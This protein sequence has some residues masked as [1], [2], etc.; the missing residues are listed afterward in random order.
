MQQ[1]ATC[2][3][4]SPPPPFSFCPKDLLSMDATALANSALGPSRSLPRSRT[5]AISAHLRRGRGWS[6]KAVM[7]SSSPSGATPPTP[8][9]HKKKKKKKKS[10]QEHKEEPDSFQ[11]RKQHP[12]PLRG[13]LQSQGNDLLAAL[14]G[15]QEGNLHVGACGKLLLFPSGKKRPKTLAL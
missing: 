15:V 11:H 5:S 3:L 7:A 2:T 13:L 6:P 1:F 14:R 10:K 8:Q 9:D 12:K 4:Q